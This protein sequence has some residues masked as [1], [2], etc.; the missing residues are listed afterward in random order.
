MGKL[1]IKVTSNAKTLSS[2]SGLHLFSDLISKFDLKALVGP[3]L[4]EKA[5]KRGFSS[6]QKFF[7]GLLG[8][9]AGAECLDDFDWLGQDPLFEQLTDSPSSITMGNF[10]RMFTARQ[11]QQIQNLLP[12]LGLKMRLWLEPNLYKIVFRMDS[13]DHEQYGWKMEGVDYGYRKVR[14][15]NSQN[16][17]DDKGLCY[18]F[19]LR[20][21]NT[22]SSK[23]AVEMMENAFR[24]VPK[25][26]QKFF[27]AD[28]A[29]GSLHIYNCLLNHNVNFAICLKENVW[30]PQLEKCKNK[31]TWHKTKLRFFD[32]DKC[33]IGSAIYS[34]KGLAAGK[35]FLRVVFIRTKKKSIKAGDN[36]PYDYYAIV[37]NMSESEMT[38]EQIIRFY[39]KRS[40]VENNIK[41]LKDGMDF[42]HFPC[43]SLKANNVWGLMGVIAYNLMRMTSFTLFP[44]TGCFVKTT[45]RKIVTLAGEVIKHA[46]FIE[47]RMMDFLSKEVNK[48]RMILCRLSFSDR[49]DRLNPLLN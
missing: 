18:G 34:L 27:V 36:H 13:S 29:Y 24:V 3:F 46:R 38:N 44:K 17:F 14:C 22:Y 20:K 42:Y 8:F 16:I 7:S 9:I 32:S 12:A 33:E 30:E 25:T 2:Y 28:S 49:E 31:I 11:I 26:I 39:R 1:S 37:T 19:D 6:F 23:G 10:L 47:I 48:L 45:R 43:Q 5:R 41:D 35:T 40:Q 15:L 4:P 21:G